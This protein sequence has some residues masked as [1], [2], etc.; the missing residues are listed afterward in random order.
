MVTT[1]GGSLS[2][3]KTESERPVSCIWGNGGSYQVRLAGLGPHHTLS[4]VQELFVKAT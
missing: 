4:K 1:Q 2:H 3:S